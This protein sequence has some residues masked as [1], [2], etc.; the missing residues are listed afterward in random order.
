MFDPF[1]LNL[2][3]S[4]MGPLGPKFQLSTNLVF[5]TTQLLVL[6]WC[7]KS[8][9]FPIALLFLRFESHTEDRKQNLHCQMVS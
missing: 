2:G 6:V 9:S 1:L 5:L 3:T 7:N 4:L 8:M